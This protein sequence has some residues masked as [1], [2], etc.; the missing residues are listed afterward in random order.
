MTAV[1][2][3]T[4]EAPS[5]QDTRSDIETFLHCL[6]I[7]LQRGSDPK[8]KSLRDSFDIDA[9]LIT[10]LQAIEVL[11]FGADQSYDWVTEKPIPTIV[12]QLFERRRLVQEEERMKRLETRLTATEQMLVESAK[13]IQAFGQE[14]AGI[15]ESLNAQAALLKRVDPEAMEL[16]SMYATES[17]DKLRA[18][19]NAVE[20]LASI[21]LAASPGDLATMVSG[22]KSKEPVKVAKKDRPKIHIGIVGLYERD[23]RHVEDKINALEVSKGF[24]LRIQQLDHVE[25]PFVLPKGLD[26]VFVGDNASKR[27]SEVKTHYGDRG[28]RWVGGFGSCAQSVEQF[29]KTLL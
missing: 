21:V 1:N 19:S 16:A 2:T 25:L 15:N 29:L 8:L 5:P 7:S 4:A 18:V 17:Q 11:E 3:E 12:D 22:F 10:E 9:A 20:R 14:I 28:Y 23:L 27:Y 26:A 24:N 6:K 13:A